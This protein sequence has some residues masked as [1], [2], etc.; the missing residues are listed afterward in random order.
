MKSSYRWT[1][2]W[3]V[4]DLERPERNES[5]WNQK[6]RIWTERKRKERKWKKKSYTGTDPWSCW[7]SI[8]VY[9]PP[10]CIIFPSSS[11]SSSSDPQI[12]L[13]FFFFFFFISFYTLKAF[14]CLRYYDKSIFASCNTHATS[15]YSVFVAKYKLN[16]G[17]N[18]FICHFV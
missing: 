1:W 17:P 2:R 5:E 10:P 14:L 8:V 6:D 3:P 11:S 12:Y 13:F 16:H 4:V 18:P 9:F 7:L 15:C